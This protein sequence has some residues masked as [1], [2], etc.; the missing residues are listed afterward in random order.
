MSLES[1]AHIQSAHES[2]MK[3]LKSINLFDETI[4]CVQLDLAVS[5]AQV[6]QRLQ[7]YLA[8]LEA[9]EKLRPDEFK[10]E[11]TRPRIEA[12][13]KQLNDLKRHQTEIVELSFKNMFE[14]STMIAR[15]K[16]SLQML[17][18][19]EAKIKALEERIAASPK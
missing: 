15:E 18:E 16:E 11:A 6:N 4:S 19:K 13:E 10:Q 17:T 2:L 5:R 3:Q 7:Q 1:G 12:L 14:M 9:L 8:Q